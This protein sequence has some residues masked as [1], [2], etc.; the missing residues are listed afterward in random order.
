M[1]ERETIQSIDNQKPLQGKIDSLRETSCPP[2][3]GGPKSMISRRGK[4]NCHVEEN[5]SL[6]LNNFVEAIPLTCTPKVRFSSLR[7]ASSPSRGEEFLDAHWK[8][9]R[10]IAFTLAEVLI[11]LGIIGVVAAITLPTLIAKYDEMVMVNKIKRTY[12]ELAN[13]IEMR[14]AEL[15]TSDYAEQFN[16]NFTATEQL[17]GFVK[18]LNVVERCPAYSKGCGG[19]YDI[20]PKQK[21]NDGFGNIQTSSANFIWTPRA[22]LNDGTLIAIY[23]RNWTDNCKVEYETY[24]KDKDGNY[25]NLV[26]GKPVPVKYQSTSCVEIFFDVNGAKGRNQ[27]GYD[28]FS[29]NVVPNKIDQHAGYGGIYDVIRTGKL[30]YEKYSLHSGKY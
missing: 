9:S 18:Y 24:E 27:F 19:E 7:T 12:S 20:F 25:K 30:T 21:T 1:S 3:A 29:F 14:K 10:K 2:L 11:T 22:V 16:P 5:G 4:I 6:S 26:D 28:V 17:N 23:K 13:A 15:G 8:N